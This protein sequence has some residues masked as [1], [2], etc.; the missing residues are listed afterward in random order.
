[1]ENFFTP[2]TFPAYLEW[3]DGIIEW[4][5]LALLAGWLV[6]ATLRAWRVQKPWSRLNWGL[7]VILAILAVGTSLFIGLRLPAEGALPRA[8]LP[9]EPRGPALL[10]LAAVPWMLAGGL[11]GPL[12]AVG[13]G[14]VSGLVRALFD[15]HSMFSVVQMAGLALF[16]TILI[17]QRY[18]TIVYRLLRLPLAASLALAVGFVPI[19]FL[20]IIL[21]ANGSLVLRVDYALTNLPRQATAAAAE[22]LIGGLIAEI[23]SRVLRELWA[24]KSEEIPS[25]AETS[26]QQRFFA[27][28][29]P[30]VIILIAALMAGSWVLSS[31]AA[32]AMLEDQLSS[33]ARLAADTFPFFQETGQNLI[34]N[35]ARETDLDVLSISQIP[36]TLAQKMR[37]LPYFRQLFIFDSTGNPLSGYPV[38]DIASLRLS[39]EEQAGIDLA[40]KGVSV[41]SYTGGVEP[42]ENSALISFI[43]A[44][45]DEQGQIQGVLLGR[46]DLASNPFT[47]PVIRTF[48]A[49]ES[50]NTDQVSTSGVKAIILDGNG[51]I[52]YH[53]AASMVMSTY[54][55][56]ILNEPAFFDETSPEGT[57][58]LVY[59]Q[60]VQGQDWAVILSVP[61]ERVQQ[62]SLTIAVP[63]LVMI[64]VIALAAVV[65]LRLS[66]KPVSSSLKRLETEAGNISRGEFDHSLQIKGVDEVGRLGQAFE[67]MRLN[68]KAHLGELN[69][70]LTVSQ[71]V[72]SS[73][74]LEGTVQP[75]LEAAL[76]GGAGNAA[77]A[78]IVLLPDAHT[79][80][81]Q[82]VVE[83]YG[84]GESSGRFAYLDEQILELAREHDSLVLPNLTRG[85]GLNFNA[86]ARP[87]AL[88]ARV[89][90]HENNLL[91]ILW[92]GYDSPHT[93]TESDVRFLTTL[94]GEA[95]MAAANTRLFARAEIGRQ[96]MEAILDATP[97][98]V[99]VTDYQ[100]R[101]MLINPAARQIP[102]IAGVSAKGQPIDSV[103]SQK[104]LLELVRLPVDGRHPHELQLDNGKVYYATVSH[105][106][107]GDQPA[108]KVCILRD[109]TQY[110]QQDETRSVFVATVSHDLRVPLSLMNGYATMLGMVGE[111]NEQQ[112]TYVRKILSGVE[113]MSHLVSNLLDLGRI[114]AGEGLKR[115]SV[116]P[117]EIVDRVVNSL[118]L[119]AAQKNIQIGRNTQE[120]VFPVISADPALLHQ[121]LYNL[122]DNA[123]KFTPVGGIV[124]VNLDSHGS[125]LV[126][127]V[128]DNGIGIAPLDQPRLFEKFYKGGQREA[129]AQR[130][131]GLGLAIVK[132]I[133]ERH[134]GR[135]WVDSSLGKGSTFNI[136]L[137]FDQ[138]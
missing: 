56:S 102:G 52:L 77:C 100:N 136:E 4:A 71:G 35:I 86:N 26:L 91:G 82:S 105:I 138:E 88:I 37:A 78:R 7:F 64:L 83:R 33:T 16:F 49:L 2:L 120:G 112:K 48:D 74:E 28:T 79:P 70:L 119:Q 39:G 127:S 14:A 75:I 111:L 68:L 117:G 13:I 47:K 115:T 62:L 89:L 45:T 76:S 110:K 122:V 12:A 123:I 36:D 5:G 61:A 59:Y 15:T 131:S 60:P 80:G 29:G 17:R 85:R 57:R 11:L 133:A 98:A 114:D 54:S 108:G 19:L 109:I 113:S 124:N 27:G 128:M 65:S 94:A 97:D 96:R 22:L 72:A 93:F 132:S 66:L 129:Y 125:G 63:L 9:E 99:L 20:L 134:G 84:Q 6:W 101:L 30:L 51:R 107:I 34:L 81:N 95:A 130:G 116:A 67:Q 41:Q 23:A 8:L 73:L 55:G 43:T 38:S 44:V 42:G 118:Q 21:Q 135:V 50:T 121:A 3:P 1:M 40:L 25:P 103:I 106:S 32:R 87:G 137:P 126:F 69:Q 53:P 46:T 90:R 58:S 31:R 104:D 92:L 18:R 24:E 10:L